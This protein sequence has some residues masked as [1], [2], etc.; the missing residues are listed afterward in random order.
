MHLGGRVRD[1]TAVPVREE[2]EWERLYGLFET[3]SP[4]YPSYR[5]WAGQRQPRLFR[6][7]ARD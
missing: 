1:V 6:L 2:G 4:N 5:A 3:L 7:V